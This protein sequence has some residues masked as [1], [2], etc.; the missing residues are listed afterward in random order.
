MLR[1]RRHLHKEDRCNVV[2]GCTNEAIVHLG[3]A[4]SCA[5]HPPPSKQALAA[6]PPC[7]HCG[8]SFWPDMF[9]FDCGPED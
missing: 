4:R 1:I 5:E 6:A 7:E 3:D 2:E 8:R 9:H